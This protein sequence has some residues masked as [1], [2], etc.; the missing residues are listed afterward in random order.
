MR[1]FGGYVKGGHRTVYVR[2][3]SKSRAASLLARKLGG[4]VRAKDVRVKMCGV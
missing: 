3:E 1:K 2:C 4:G